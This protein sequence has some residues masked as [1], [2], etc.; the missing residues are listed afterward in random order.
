[1]KSETDLVL[2]K[3]NKDLLQKIIKE[4]KNWKEIQ[5]ELI[6]RIQENHKN[7]KKSV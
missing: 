3:I 2:L 6:K 7:N 5:K 4:F 1:V